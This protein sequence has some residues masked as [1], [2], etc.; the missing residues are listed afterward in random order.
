[1]ITPEEYDAAAIIE[2]WAIGEEDDRRE[3]AR[4]LILAR[5][6]SAIQAAGYARRSVMDAVAAV[7]RAID[8]LG[9]D[10]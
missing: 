4:A 5:G 7:S 1:M 6:E 3:A 8:V 10:A 2:R 9:L